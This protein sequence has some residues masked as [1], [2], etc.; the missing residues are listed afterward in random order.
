MSVWLTNR[1]WIASLD[2]Y[3]L[4]FILKLFVNMRFEIRFWIAS[5]DFYFLF[6]ILKLFVNMRFEINFSGV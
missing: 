3:F 1:F 2:F 6:F 5:L 4:F